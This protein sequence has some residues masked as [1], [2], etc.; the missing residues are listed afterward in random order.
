MEEAKVCQAFE[1]VFY[2]LPVQCETPTEKRLTRDL[3]LYHECRG[4]WFVAEKVKQSGFQR[5]GAAF[6]NLGEA[7]ALSGFEYTTVWEGTDK[8][9][10]E[11]LATIS[12]T[13]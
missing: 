7:S 13:K 5:L 6:R 2:Y 8:P 10:A 4:P 3:L 11:E 9:T 12:R 1:N